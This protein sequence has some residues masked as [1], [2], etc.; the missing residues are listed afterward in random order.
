VDGAS[1]VKTYC[2][3]GAEDVG[4]VQELGSTSANPNMCVRSLSHATGVVTSAVPVLLASHKP[5]VYEVFGVV[6]SSLEQPGKGLLLF[7][8][9]AEDDSQLYIANK[10]V[11]ELK[12]NIF[13]ERALGSVLLEPGSMP[14]RFR[15]ANT[16]GIGLLRL[17]LLLA[18]GEP[19]SARCVEQ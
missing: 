16:R 15:F 17:D 4:V 5:E 8:A 19:A 10:L 1:E 14:V 11:W 12:S 7:D 13:Q 2:L 18:S 3:E 6:D 9:L